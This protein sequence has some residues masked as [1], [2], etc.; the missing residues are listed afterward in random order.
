MVRFFF[1]M[2][3]NG[4]Q[5]KGTNHCAKGNELQWKG[6]N[7]HAKG[8]GLQWKGTKRCAKGKHRIQKSEYATTF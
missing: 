3:G 4:L 7:P 1:Y 2:K 5:W 6:T 8:N